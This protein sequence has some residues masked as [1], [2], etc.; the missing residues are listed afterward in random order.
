[1]GAAA[2]SLGGD[3]RVTRHA[4]ARMSGRAVS[5]RAVRAVVEFGRIRDVRGA[6]I[7][8]VG[9]K[10]VERFRREG[11]DLSE[12]EGIQVVCAEDAVLTVYR[13]RDLRSLRPRRRPARR[14][15][16]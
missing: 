4:W 6:T 3:L 14:A 7:Y 9:K 5:P 1:M 12:L 10:E 2:R 16:A 13:N 11:V 15:R 8:A